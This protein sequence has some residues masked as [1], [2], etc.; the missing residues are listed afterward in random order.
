MKLAKT[1]GIFF[2][3]VSFSFIAA[4]AYAADTITKH[5]LGGMEYP[6]YP[7]PTYGKGSQAQLIRKGEYL[8]K[9]GDCIACHTDS[10]NG[11]KPFSGGLSLKTPFGLFYSA[12]ITPDKE[13][14]IGSWSD[15]DFIK[16]MRKGIRPD[17][18]Y[19]F[20]VFPYTSFTKIN[21][22]DL[23]AIKAYL[24]S[25]PPVH[26]EN[27]KPGA[28]W[29]VSWRFMQLG[30]R[31]LFFRESAYQYD[32]KQSAEWNRGAYLV[33]GLGH[34][35]ECHTP[36]NLL[37]A[38]KSKNFLTGAFV[39]GYYAPDITGYGLKG[40]SNTQVEAVFTK[41]QMLKNAGAVQGPMA[42]VDHNSLRYM[43]NQD[44]M[45]IVTYLKTV[46]SVEP[47]T[48]SG[49]VGAGTGKKIYQSHC[50]VC[51]NTGAAGAPKL[52]DTAAWEPR[53]KQGMAVVF[54]H[55]INGYN[56]MPPKGTCMSCS[57]DEIKAAVQYLADQSKPGAAGAG[58]PATIAPPPQPTMADG[59]RIYEK[60]CS[61]CHAQGIGGAPKL[62]DKAAWAPLIKQN[63]DVLFGHT[64][65]G[66]NNMPAR[67]NCTSCTNAE[68]EAAVK[69]MAQQSSDGNYSLW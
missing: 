22:D 52:G 29:P 62:G 45:A 28:P 33:Q 30:W 61:V 66:Y 14:G 69:Y 43:S 16:A 10:P 2:S 23:I 40:A 34:C 53:I 50:A 56:S 68:L 46:K 24:F 18:S 6:A 13:T 4:S 51:H 32:S 25:L 47:K 36:R 3:A 9:A 15:Q 38:V 5:Q 26:K 20:P 21:D 31:M 44:L 27:K 11:G 49:P 60:S 48:S 65:N 54:Q 57:D 39:D 59:K 63:M 12:N 19:Y 67:G 42:E 58:V 35:G 7:Q 17:G 55:A 37:G 64:I 1:I 41:E 8:V